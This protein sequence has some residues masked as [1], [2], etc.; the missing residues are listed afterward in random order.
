MAGN[1]RNLGGGGIGR[2]L[3]AA[4]AGLGVAVLFIGLGLWLMAGTAQACDTVTGQGCDMTSSSVPSNGSTPPTGAQPP[5]ATASA[6]TT[7]PAV[8]GPFIPPSATTPTSASTASPDATPSTETTPST[9]ATPSTSATPSTG[10]TVSS[11][12]ASS[13]GSGGGLSGQDLALLAL[14]VTVA[15][16]GGAAVVAVARRDT[17]D[18]TGDYANTCSEF[19]WMRQAEAQADADVSAAQTGLAQAQQAWM[20]AQS[21]LANQLRDDYIRS[22]TLRSFGTRV[23]TLA[24]GPLTWGGIP[25]G[26]ITFPGLGDYLFSAPHWYQEVSDALPAAQ[27]QVDQMGSAA[28]QAWQAKLADAT[29]RQSELFD[30]RHAAELKLVTLRAD[31]PD[32]AF[33]DCNCA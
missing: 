11:E 33:P 19:C 29:R 17:T 31:H 8:G 9:A 14:G 3:R 28:V 25:A 5:P 2:A 30:G 4:L 13:G 7:A 21:Y 32:I 22:K 1:G 23:L 16:V 12:P 24:G 26:S 6:P 18:P 15:G 27:A 10:S 20:Q